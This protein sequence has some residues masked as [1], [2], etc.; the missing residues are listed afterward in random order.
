MGSQIK[1]YLKQPTINAETL[2]LCRVYNSRSDNFKKS[3]GIKLH[4][5]D[6]NTEK[7]TV[8]KTNPHSK[9]L[10]LL[11]QQITADYTTHALNA[12]LQGQILTKTYLTNNSKFSKKKGNTGTYF[13]VWDTY[14]SNKKNEITQSTVRRYDVVKKH[15][16]EFEKHSSYKLTFQSV[17]IVFY[18]LFVDYL[19]HVKAFHNQH[20]SRVIKFVR[21]FQNYTF[22]NG[23]HNN[24]DFKKFKP[25]IA[26]RGAE[27]LGWQD[28]KKP[29]RTVAAKL[30]GC[31]NARG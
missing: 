13:D 2:L 28:Q 17:N 9:E 10:N 30:N 15:L 6:W 31:R 27:H 11:L 5:K 1:Y 3:T 23:F 8:K 7:Q 25:F 29:G 18:N 12:N 21:C 22:E 24:I 16:I 26:R 20:L 4:P 14:V 19:L